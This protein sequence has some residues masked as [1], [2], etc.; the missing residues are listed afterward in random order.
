MYSAPLPTCC[1]LEAG[2]IYPGTEP[3]TASFN[4]FRKTFTVHTETKYN[5]HYSTNVSLCICKEK[6]IFSG[7][8]EFEI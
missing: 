6:D 8:K 1:E 3:E 7:E 2:M 4:L 5:G